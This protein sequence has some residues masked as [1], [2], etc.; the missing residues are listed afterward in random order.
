M[1][2]KR[3]PRGGGSKVSEI[4]NKFQAQIPNTCD[5]SM[6][7]KAK[8]DTTSQDLVEEVS[9]GNVVRTESHVTRFNHARALFEKLGE[10]TRNNCEKH[11]VPVTVKRINSCDLKLKVNVS[12]SETIN[13]HEE[14]S[15][16][17]SPKLTKGND[18]VFP[19]DH[20]GFISKTNG[21]KSISSNETSC[22]TDENQ[23]RIKSNFLLKTNKPEKP[24][25][26][27]RKLNSKELIEKQRNWTSHF[28]KS[29]IIRYNSDPNKNE[30]Q[31][32]VNEKENDSNRQITSR[33][34][35][36]I[37]KTTLLAQPEYAEN[38]RRKNISK[39]ERPASVIP[40]ICSNI[41]VN[42]ENSAPKTTHF[43]EVHKRK[44]KSA[45][46]ILVS[47]GSNTAEFLS[48]CH[49]EQNKC[50]PDD[51]SNTRNEHNSEKLSRYFLP[52]Q[53]DEV[54][55]DVANLESPRISDNFV[56]PVS[57]SKANSELEK[58]ENEEN[59][60]SLGKSNE[61]AFTLGC[62]FYSEEVSKSPMGQSDE[63]KSR[64]NLVC[65]MD[66]FAPGYVDCSQ[67]TVMTPIEEQF[68][69]STKILEKHLSQINHQLLSDEEAQEVVRLLIPSKSIAEDATV[70]TCGDSL[71]DSKRPCDTSMISEVSESTDFEEAI[72]TDKV[73][74][75]D[76][77]LDE[78][79]VHSQQKDYVPD[80]IPIVGVE[81]GVHY[82]EDG[83][84]WM[85]VPGLLPEDLTEEE[86][87][88]KCS[89]RYSKQSKV[90]FSTEP[91]KVYSTF[92]IT[93]YDRRNEDVDP[94]AASAEYELE[95]RVEKMD[96]FPVELV[97]GSEGLGL[98]IIGM[99]VGADAGL[100]KLGI[101]VKTITT[102]GAA[103]KDGR[104]KVNDQIIE[105][106]GKSLVGVTQAY[107][108]SVLR[109][110]SGLVKF[111]IG[112]E[113]DPENSEVAQLIRQS[114]QA[115]KEREER[116]QKTMETE[117]QQSDASTVPL[118][119]SA[120]TS[121]S[122]GP[123]SPVVNHENLMDSEQNME[124]E[125]LKM[126]LQQLIEHHA[127]QPDII[128]KLEQMSQQI[129]GLEKM[130][131]TAR[132]EI[133]TYQSMLEQSQSQYLVVERKYMKTKQILREYQN[134]ELDLMHREDYYQQLL[135]EK[136]TEYNALVKNLKDRII[137]LEQ[138]VLETRQEAGLPCVLPQDHANIKQR[139]AQVLEKGPPN[140]LIPEISNNL[141]DLE[142]SDPSPD[143]DKT[144]TV[145]RK[146][147]LKEELDSVV[148]QHELL[149]ISANKRKAELATRGALA[150][151]Q[152]PSTKKGS[153]SNS[154]SS[155][156]GLDES[157][158]SGDELNIYAQP[159]DSCYCGAKE[160]RS[161]C[162]ST[163][164]SSTTYKT[165]Y[166][167]ADTQ[168]DPTPLYAEVCKSSS[169]TAPGKQKKCVA[170]GVGPPSS[171][172]EQLKQGR[173]LSDSSPVQDY[174]SVRNAPS[175]QIPESHSVP[176]SR[177]EISLA[178]PYPI[179]R[180]RLHPWCVQDFTG[181][182]PFQS[183]NPKIN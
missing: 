127:F 170:T 23:K 180:R 165:I 142:I 182:C 145:E 157:F 89:I 42:L 94:V 36:L 108:A 43:N 175:A 104:I 7:I 52:V 102:N 11:V 122:D 181:S 141:S 20:I 154:S 120:N 100:E 28:S 85:E 26:P 150:N 176:I 35:S 38:F 86:E 96:V 128:E 80:I 45:S 179:W 91:M 53:N 169:H 3:T 111:S 81:D 126:L 55:N 134:R 27:E 124:V 87:D 33:N 19:D 106:D 82:F 24:E 125:L 2:E 118:T 105:V 148:P 97:K 22:K 139:I 149:D 9:G 70:N 123:N 66:E 164:R 146:L 29:R 115:D 173:V 14:R 88:T 162:T 56:I 92:S 31:F 68:M 40:T 1:E 143:E 112:R 65:D 47:S 69:L 93:E 166:S 18:V 137:I 117:Q 158:N 136:D 49:S 59:E 135:Q 62:N 6:K 37:S 167:T 178:T 79:V 114:L 177:N 101:F 183:N 60:K 15:R 51:I 48:K 99:G 155:D 13:S 103:A 132:K 41:E 63:I 130:L 58:Q 78:S 71:H 16:S 10:E 138:D 160:K 129:R 98:S 163:G 17:P 119:G 61:E 75:I 151:R 84:F 171:L 8:V 113:R 172:A 144:A 72:K 153:L 39:K 32:V 44:E 131:S 67:A 90:S 140:I 5:A 152:L 57:S 50:L 95:K 133:Q 109:N 110:T 174:G 168:N 107:A 156:Y 54:H 46:W 21:I 121:V 76:T 25:K 147:P 34:I 116:R 4:A 12:Q 73:D 74:E 64:V 30:I 161:T 159:Q 83:H 77:F